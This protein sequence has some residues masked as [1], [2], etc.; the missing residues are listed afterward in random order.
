MHVTHAP[1]KTGLFLQFRTWT[2]SV[3]EGNHQM[4]KDVFKFSFFPRTLKDW[5]NLPEEIVL[6]DSLNIFK[7]RLSNYLV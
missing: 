5:N 6:S 1:Q 4:T 7:D 2:A 3:H